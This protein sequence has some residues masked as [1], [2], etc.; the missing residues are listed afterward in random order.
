MKIDMTGIRAA[1]AKYC[2]MNGYQAT[3]CFTIEEKE[4]LIKMFFN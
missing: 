3:V 1:Y 2:K 4:I